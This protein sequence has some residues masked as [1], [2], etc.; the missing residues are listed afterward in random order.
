MSRITH[1]FIDIGEVLLTNGWDHNSRREAAIFFK[2]NWN[3]LEE[4]H[5]LAFPGYEAGNFDLEEYLNLVIFFEKRSFSKAQFRRFMF[6]QSKAYP[7]MFELLAKLKAE[8]KLKVVAVS[9]EARELNAY[10]IEKFKLYDYIDFFISSCFVH[11][12]KPDAAIYRLALELSQAKI[13]Q[14][15]YIENTPLF[16]RV[17]E[18]LGIRT[19]L[20]KDY[21]STCAKLTKLNLV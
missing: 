20:H 9:N 14:V 17:A 8:Y 12:R 19:I 3:D 13:D 7:K 4:R 5:R 1:L 18:S 21:E 11:I 6:A 10:R 15:I 16:V 2:L